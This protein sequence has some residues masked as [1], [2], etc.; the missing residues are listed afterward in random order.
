MPG[1]EGPWGVM[2]KEEGVSVCWDLG[3]VPQSPLLST[4]YSRLPLRV[5]CYLQGQSLPIIL[6]GNGCFPFT[7]IQVHVS[8][9][10]FIHSVLLAK[11]QNVFCLLEIC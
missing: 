9:L 10:N 11:S 2:A 8:M 6:G 5:E 1:F 4:L 7:K 3:M